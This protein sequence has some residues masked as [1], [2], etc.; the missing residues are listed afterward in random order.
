VSHGPAIYDLWYSTT[1]PDGPWIAIAG[2]IDPPR[3]FDWVVPDTPSNQ[4]RVRVKQ[5]NADEDYFDVSDSD[6]A[7]VSAAEGVP[8]VLDAEKDATIHEEGN[9]TDAN[10]AGS[11]LFTGRTASQGGSAERRALIAFP[12]AES[13]PEGSTI[14]SVSLDLTMSK[15]ISGVQTV[16]L[17][18][19]LEEW[20]EG[21][22]DPSGSEGGGTSPV[23]GDVT[24]VHRE[25]PR[26][27]WATPGATFAQTASA[28]LQ[29]S[30][31]GGYTF[32]STPGLIADV[33]AWLDDPSAN[34]GWALVMDSPATGSAKRFDS[35]E[36]NGTSNRPKLSV[37]YEAD[38]QQPTA[39]FSFAPAN[40]QPGEEVRFSDAST[41][42]PT[43]WHWDFGDG[44]TSQQQSPAHVYATSGTKTVTLVVSNASGSDSVVKEVR[45]GTPVR[46]PSRRVAPSG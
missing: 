35:R 45:V 19:L 4:V 2:G 25:F 34:F 13:I 15:T 20:S 7:I 30:D 40:P 17:H 10:G 3:S 37:N 16:G 31:V 33:Q 24:W 1:G 46:R 28:T 39:G 29:V 22:S 8:I 9:G 6:L 36:N 44:Q 11:Y 41:G 23:E 27:F 26:V 43:S 18:R 32:S 38:F 42:E 21:L 14:I 12:I 5:D